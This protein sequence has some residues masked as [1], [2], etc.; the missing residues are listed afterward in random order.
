MEEVITYQRIYYVTKD[1]S[2]ITIAFNKYD[3]KHPPPSNCTTVG[4]V[5]LK[6]NVPSHVESA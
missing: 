3:R 1:P 2:S 6:D 4:W 5:V